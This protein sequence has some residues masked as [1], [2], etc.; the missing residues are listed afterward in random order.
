MCIRDRSAKEET[1][2]ETNQEETQPENTDQSSNTDQTSNNDD[3]N[4]NR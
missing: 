3:E 2:T 4:N 1:T